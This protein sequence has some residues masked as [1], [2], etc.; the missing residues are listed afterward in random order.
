MK[1]QAKR[2]RAG[3]IA[4]WPAEA[5]SETELHRIAARG[6]D[7]G[8]GRSR[9]F[10][11]HCRRCAGGGNHAHLTTNEFARQCRQSIVLAL[12]PVVFDR[13][14]APLYVTSLTQAPPERRNAVCVR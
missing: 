6:E 3:E 14:V 13:D 10:C 1:L 5:G 12:C 2:G 8:N 11:S 4:A 7:N 9:R